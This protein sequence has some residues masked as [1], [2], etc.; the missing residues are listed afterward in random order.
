MLMF[1]IHVILV[2]IVINVMWIVGR[3]VLVLTDELAMTWDIRRMEKQI[4]KN[5]SSVDS[6]VQQQDSDARIFEVVEEIRH[7]FA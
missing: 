5:S 3:M 1:T 7:D 4:L 2:L 6:F